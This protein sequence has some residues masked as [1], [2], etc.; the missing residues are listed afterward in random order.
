[1][2]LL[3]DLLQIKQNSQLHKPSNQESFLLILYFESSL[4][5][6]RF[7][8]LCSRIISPIIFRLLRRFASRNDEPVIAS[9]AKQSPLF[10]KLFT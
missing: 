8:E 5:Q 7:L 9:V 3:Q 4:F 1:M 10:Y 2:E 6:A